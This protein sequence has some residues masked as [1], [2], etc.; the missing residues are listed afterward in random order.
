VCWRKVLRYF[1]KTSQRANKRST[2]KRINRRYAYVHPGKKIQRQAKI[3]IAIDQSGSVDNQMLSMFFAELNNLAKLAEFTVIP[4]DSDVDESL[5]YVWKKGESRR[6]ERVLSGGTDF[7]APTDYVNS[8]NFDGVIILTDM[9][10]PKPKN[11]KA[12][13]MWMTDAQGKTKAHFQTREKVIAI[14]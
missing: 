6:R 7:N 5:V 9:E 13:R 1:I 8:H 3:A 2:I 12:Q 11:C 4:F 10:A 14:D